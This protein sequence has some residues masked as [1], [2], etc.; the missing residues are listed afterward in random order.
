MTRYIKI[1]PYATKSSDI[2]LHDGNYDSDKKTRNIFISR[3]FS[4]LFQRQGEASPVD[5]FADDAQISL[6]TRDDRISGKGGFEN[7]GIPEKELMDFECLS[8]F[9][10]G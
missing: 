1:P 3:I 10:E 2:T 8:L 9:I 6:R 5:T 7:P 4:F